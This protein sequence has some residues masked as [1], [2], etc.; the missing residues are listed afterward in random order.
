MSM[1]V[2]VNWARTTVDCD[3]CD[4]TVIEHTSTTMATMDID[5]L[6]I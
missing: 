6:Y 1:L 4:S 3:L 2:D 5:A